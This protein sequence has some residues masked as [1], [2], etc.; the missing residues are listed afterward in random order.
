MNSASAMRSIVEAKQ[1]GVIVAAAL[2]LA[3][4]LG[5]AAKAR[6]QGLPG[7]P[8]DECAL[9]GMAFPLEP[10]PEF[11]PVTSNV[12]RVATSA[13]TW[14]YAW[15]NF[16]PNQNPAAPLLVPSEPT[17]WDAQWFDQG[18]P[19]LDPYPSACWSTLA[20]NSFGEGLG[21]TSA[22]REMDLPLGGRLG[23]NLLAAPSPGDF[24]D[25]APTIGQSSLCLLPA[26]AAGMATGWQGASRPTLEGVVDLV[27]G[28]PL[29]KVT[30]LELPLDGATFRIS[31]TRSANAAVTTYG[32][33]PIADRIDGPDRW[34]DW[35]GQGWMASENPILLIDGHLPD[36]LTSQAPRTTTLWLDAHHSI[37]FQM[38]PH[39]DTQTVEYEAPP[40]FRARL[41]H[42]GTW[43]LS[44]ENHSE[45]YWSTPPTQSGSCFRPHHQPEV[46]GPGVPGHNAGA[47]GLGAGGGQPEL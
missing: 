18:Y 32:N 45:D 23:M 25:P 11:V 6:G 8:D 1:H 40:R 15:R 14:Q 26:G 37:P 42:N 13:T 38:V 29:I 28:L 7:N 41:E 34:W 33:S 17:S 27:T 5:V 21:Y 10:S 2:A 46:R 12:Q 43:H 16:G 4:F 44:D 30:D 36:V 20:S 9:A 24:L 39:S 19:R 47:A 35:V 31:R 3:L 22:A